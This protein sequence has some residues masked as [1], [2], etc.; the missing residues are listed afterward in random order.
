MKRKVVKVHLAVDKDSRKILVGIC[1]K[2]WK[3]EH[4]FGV[5]IVKSLRQALSKQGKIIKAELLDSGYLS[6]EMTDEIEKSKA[7]PYIKMKKNKS[8]GNS[9]WKQN[10]LF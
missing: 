7:R 2:S 8:K 1:S 3:H 4:K 5:Q 10:I 6:R 9:S